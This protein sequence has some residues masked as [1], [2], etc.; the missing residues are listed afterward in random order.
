MGENMIH[1]IIKPHRPSFHYHVILQA[2]EIV[3][4]ERRINDPAG[5]IW[6]TPARKNPCWVPEAW[7]EIHRRHA[8][9]LKP[10]N[11]LELKVE[12]G[13]EIEIEFEQ[14]GWAW[15]TNSEKVSGWIPL[16]CINFKKRL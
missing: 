3:K 15:V 12:R 7:L 8:V 10:Y 4:Y 2:G 11:S 14:S 13:E 6:C 1:G 5:W 9:L 16:E